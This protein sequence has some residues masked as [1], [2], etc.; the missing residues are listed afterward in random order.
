MGN[1]VFTVKAGIKKKNKQKRSIVIIYCKVIFL[2]MET[3]PLEKPSLSCKYTPQFYS[4]SK[5]AQ[6]GI[7]EKVSVVRGIEKGMGF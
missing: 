2:T 4:N 6:K 5:K 7:S 3:E 1:I